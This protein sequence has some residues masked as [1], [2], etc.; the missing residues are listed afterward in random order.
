MLLSASGRFSPVLAPA[1]SGWWPVLGL[2]L[3][4]LCRHRSDSYAAASLIASSNEPGVLTN[5]LP[6]VFE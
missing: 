5:A 3:Q 1:F 6:R 2:R 4:R